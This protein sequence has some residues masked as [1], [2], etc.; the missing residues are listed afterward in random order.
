MPG[1]FSLNRNTFERTTL[2]SKRFPPNNLIFSRPQ[3]IPRKHL[4]PPPHFHNQRRTRFRHRRP[5]HH[6]QHRR[7]RFHR[8]PPSKP[9]R[10]RNPPQPRIR[11]LCQID[12]DHPKP[13]RMNHQIRRAHGMLNISGTSNPDQFRKLD[14]TSCGRA[15]IKPVR[16]IDHRRKLTPAGGSSQ[17]RM[18][19]TSPPTRP[20]PDNFRNAPARTIDCSRKSIRFKID[21]PSNCGNKHFRLF[22][23]Y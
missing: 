1:V 10:S 9:C 8:A 4:S 11:R 7:S 23:A 21:S 19:Q 2:P 16:S 6:H 3:Q 17:C 14:P 12:S 13:T 22:F 15:W 18:Q 20:R 5:S